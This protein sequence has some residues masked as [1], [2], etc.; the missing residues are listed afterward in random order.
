MKVDKGKESERREGVRRVKVEKE[1]RKVKVEK[2]EE[3]RWR[4]G[5][6]SESGERI[7]ESEGGERVRRVKVKNA[8]RKGKVEKG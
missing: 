5:K 6:K 1:S 8:S 3:W 2:R 4:R 7:K